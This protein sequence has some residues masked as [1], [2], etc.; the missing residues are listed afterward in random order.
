MTGTCLFG[1]IWFDIPACLFRFLPGLKL[2]FLF[3][4]QTDIKI[5]LL[6]EKK[7]IWLDLSLLEQQT[8]IINSE[9]SF[10]LINLLN[11]YLKSLLFFKSSKRAHR[12]CGMAGLYGQ[13]C[14][15]GLCG[16][17]RTVPNLKAKKVQ[18][19]MLVFIF[20][21]CTFIPMPCSL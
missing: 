16:S 13:L 10:V 18:K 17:D 15:C 2:F 21:L 5:L 12:D 4:C 19:S 1:T 6:K 3:I 8:N 7:V 11:R 9:G 14:D 20:I